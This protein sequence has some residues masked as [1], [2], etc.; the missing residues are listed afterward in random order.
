MPPS[1]QREKRAEDG[2]RRDQCESAEAHRISR[3][4]LRLRPDP[5]PAGVGAGGR[6]PA[7]RRLTQQTRPTASGRAISLKKPRV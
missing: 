5:S 1:R 7:F 2:D 6:S 4:P 3:T